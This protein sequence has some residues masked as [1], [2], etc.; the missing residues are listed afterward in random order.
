MLK[1]FAAVVM[2]TVSSLSWA[3]TPY[4]LAEKH[5]PA[6][7]TKV[8]EEVEAK[9]KAAGFQVVGR[10]FPR[11]LPQYGVVVVTD[12]GIL[13]TV[14]DLGGANVLGAAIRVGV[15]SDGTVTYMNPDYWYRAYFRGQFGKAEKQV[16]AVKEKLG[17]TLGA[18]MG[19]GGDEK[20][21]DL[22]KYRYII[23]M[24]RFD[25]DKNR[26]AEHVSFD[27]AVK[28]VQDNLAKGVA[29]T[30]KVYE[31]II[32][33]KKIAVF[34]V[35]MNDETLGDGRWIAK[36]GGQESIAALPY[37]LYVV[38]NTVNALFGRYRI[39][40]AFPDLSMGHFTRIMS[41]PSEIVE[42]LGAVAGARPA[43]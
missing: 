31:V 23:G 5:K 14:R 43:N 2:L 36:I 6:E 29:H 39:A 10:Y 32:P 34:G 4:I 3:I 22:P 7:T 40:L 9:L 27:E 26:L 13:N 17:R 33:E 25:S 11:Q 8:A 38:N 37:E 42:I 35:A 16:A 21:E 30:G 12:E 41:T 24:E 19:F 28:T 1:I 20:A 18:G 15:K